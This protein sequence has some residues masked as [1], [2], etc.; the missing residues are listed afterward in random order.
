MLAAEPS[1]VVC[2]KWKK[3]LMK[4]GEVFHTQCRTEVETVEDKGYGREIRASVFWIFTDGTLEQVI[5]ES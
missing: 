3:W 2:V 4:T 1:M 5:G